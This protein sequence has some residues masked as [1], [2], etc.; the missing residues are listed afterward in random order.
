M[1]CPTP[2]RRWSGTE[3][4][5]VV[6]GRR[7]GGLPFP[8]GCG[9]ARSVIGQRLP[10][11]NVLVGYRADTVVRPYAPV[12]GPHRGP[13]AT[14]SCRCSAPDF[15][16]GLN[17][18]RLSETENGG[19]G[20][21]VLRSSTRRGRS[22]PATSGSVRE[23]LGRASLGVQSG[24]KPRRTETG[25]RLDPDHVHRV[26]D[27]PSLVLPARGSGLAQGWLKVGDRGRVRPRRRRGG[28]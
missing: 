13:I 19:G 21:R 25:R 28:R 7:R 15:N 9:S 14:S 18:R 4:G 16:P 3:P 6:G 10:S 23:G 17:L 2:T 20:M 24:V 22:P 8:P 12:V 26:P 11:W 5:R 27:G 1:R